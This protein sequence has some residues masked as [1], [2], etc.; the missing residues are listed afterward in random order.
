MPEDRYEK[1]DLMQQ[2]KSFMPADYRLCLQ[3]GKYKDERRF[4]E[5][6]DD[7][8]PGYIQ[9]WDDPWNGNGYTLDD[10]MMLMM[11]DSGEPSSAL[12]AE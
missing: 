9:H 12:T 2:L 4:E 3:C 8:I 11:G 5:V 1:L 6:E 10:L 7:D